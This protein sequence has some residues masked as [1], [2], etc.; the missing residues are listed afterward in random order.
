MSLL[1]LII[2]GCGLL[3]CLVGLAQTLQSRAGVSENLHDALVT[4]EQEAFMVD[5]GWRPWAANASEEEQEQALK[6]YLEDRPVRWYRP[7]QVEQPIV[8]TG[9]LQVPDEVKRSFWSL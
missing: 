5:H 1:L 3:A 2:L 9:K 6:A 4:R 7:R 8:T